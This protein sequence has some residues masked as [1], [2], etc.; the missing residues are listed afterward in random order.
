MTIRPDPAPTTSRAARQHVV[1]ESSTVL[2][3]ISASLSSRGA[4]GRTALDCSRRLNYG[5]N[6][7]SAASV[8]LWP[9]LAP[10]R[11]IHG[12][13]SDENYAL[14]RRRRSPAAVVSLSANFEE[15]DLALSG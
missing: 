13:S 4:A 1:W 14:D 7:S 9:V 8:W 10:N 15:N 11:T 5:L 2:L 6:T 3:C 12:S